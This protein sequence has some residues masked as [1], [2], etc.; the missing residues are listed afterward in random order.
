MYCWRA[1]SSSSFS[2]CSALKMVRTRLVR[3]DEEVERVA[4]EDEEAA[5]IDTAVCGDDSEDPEEDKHLFL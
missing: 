3:G 4:V 2:N 5:V 1:N